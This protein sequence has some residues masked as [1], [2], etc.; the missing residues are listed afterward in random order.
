[1]DISTLH[2]LSINWTNITYYWIDPN[3]KWRFQKATLFW[4]NIFGITNYSFVANDCSPFK[5]RKQCGRKLLFGKEIL[6]INENGT[7]ALKKSM[8]YIKNGT[9]T[10][11]IQE[12]DFPILKLHFKSHF[13][14]SWF[15]IKNDGKSIT[16][17]PTSLDDDIPFE[18]IKNTRHSR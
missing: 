16:L 9:G 11:E 7:F 1:L 2:Y 13:G 10:W 4:F 18:L 8:L 17:S 14:D 15:E 6:T 12:I 5:I 3:Q